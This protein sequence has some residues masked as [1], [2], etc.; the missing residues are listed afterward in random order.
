M[1]D[2]H[3]TVVLFVH[4]PHNVGGDSMVLLR[5]VEHLDRTSFDPVVVATPDCE[6]WER[7]R[8]LAET[9]AVRLYPLNAGVWGEDTPNRSRHTQALL[10]AR[11]IGELIQLIHRESV[12][13]VY[14][15]DRSR[16]VALATIAARLLGRGVV[17]HAHCPYYPS[18]RFRT[19]I[20][21]AADAVVVVSDFI[22][23]EYAQRGIPA[24]RMHTILNGV[25]ISRYGAPSDRQGLR[26]ELGMSPEELLV[27]V[28]ARLSRAK[29]QWELLDALPTVLRSFPD[30]RVVFAGWDTPEFGDLATLAS[31]ADSSFRALLERRAAELGV[32]NQIVFP[33][34]VRDMPALYAAADIV[35]LPSWVDPC[36][37]SVIEAMASGRAV[38]GAAEGGIP[39]LIASEHTGLL[40]PARQPEALASALIRL[41]SDAPLRQRLEQAAQAHAREHLSIQQYC[42]SLEAVLLSVAGRRR[43]SARLGGPERFAS[44]VAAQ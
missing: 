16:V 42:S 19:A 9:G 40:V 13:V 6:A 39:E 36:P 25:D 8:A 33:G 26:R 44:Q 23:R 15:L 29:G 41:L 1:S 32:A 18:S 28:P 24:V 2:Q 3:R 7:L 5:T 22:Q 11:A 27:L 34:S 12:D 43:R 37:L 38:I 31:P 30:V 21:R 4:G 14:T 35:A 10:M 17:F 20:V